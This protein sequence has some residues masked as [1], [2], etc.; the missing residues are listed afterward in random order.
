MGAEP[1]VPPSVARTS[2]FLSDSEDPLAE[3]KQ[4]FLGPHTELAL[5]LVAA[6]RDTDG[7][8]LGELLVPDWRELGVP[9]DMPACP[10]SG[11]RSGKPMNR[12]ALLTMS[13]CW[14]EVLDDLDRIRV[15]YIAHFGTVPT[16]FSDVRRFAKVV[17]AVPAYLFRRVDRPFRDAQLPPRI[18]A[19][20]KA[21][22]GV[23]GVGLR[24]LAVGDDPVFEPAVAHA[25]L[26]SVDAFN[27][28][29]FTASVCAGPPKLIDDFLAA[30]VARPAG[31]PHAAPSID[32]LI[33]DWTQFFDYAAALHRLELTCRLF[34]ARAANRFLQLQRDLDALPCDPG[35]AAALRATLAQEVAL[36]GPPKPMGV[37]WL[38]RLLHGELRAAGCTVEARL[39]Q[40]WPYAMTDE[41]VRRFTE[42]AASGALIPRLVEVAATALAEYLDLEHGTRVA[43][44][45][46]QR[47]LLAILGRGAEVEVDADLIEQSLMRRT[48]SLRGSLSKLL[49]LEIESSLEG[50]RVS[51]PGGTG[52]YTWHPAAE[53]R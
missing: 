3:L 47:A 8:P 11:T 15:Q 25:Y 20:Y 35:R 7:R 5:G 19:L 26:E 14:K 48:P 17:T 27:G 2:A 44:T 24:Q 43:L 6:L 36:K 51:R 9:F 21:M 50:L 31:L 30:V 38:A 42:F 4:A 29:P 34:Q 28:E 39:T 13:S 12:S 22:A 52:D 23:V 37:D 18:S 32:E 46:L 40:R 16:T 1:K 41:A 10:Y 53:A 33:G 49:G 45:Q